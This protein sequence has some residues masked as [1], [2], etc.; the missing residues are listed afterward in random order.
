M[1]TEAG[2]GFGFRRVHQVTIAFDGP[3]PVAT[4]TGVLHRYPQVLRVP[5]RVASSLVAAGAPLRITR[6]GGPR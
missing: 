3:A 4:V 6:T 1:G 5:L 2:T